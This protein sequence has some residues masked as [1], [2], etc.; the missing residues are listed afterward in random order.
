MIVN[1][2]LEFI[3]K[4]VIKNQARFR[5]FKFISGR[6]FNAVALGSNR[7]NSIGFKDKILNVDV[8]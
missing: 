2:L 5:F 6:V 3:G 1:Y 8:S 7:G 4:I